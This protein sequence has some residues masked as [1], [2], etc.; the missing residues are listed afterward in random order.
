M[1]A[2]SLGHDEIWPAC[3]RPSEYEK[4]V[5]Y[6]FGTREK[7]GPGKGAYSRAMPL[8]TGDH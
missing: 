8:R 5:Y 7:A 4:S 1:D 3:G 2:R 6:K